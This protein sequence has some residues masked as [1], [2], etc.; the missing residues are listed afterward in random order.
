MGAWVIEFLPTFY[1]F[2]DSP[3]NYLRSY[4]LQWGR[5]DTLSKLQSRLSSPVGGVDYR[6]IT[7]L[8]SG[9]PPIPSGTKPYFTADI[10]LQLVSI[11]T[12]DWP[13]SSKRANFVLDGPFVVDRL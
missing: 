10:P 3:A 13:Y 5:A 9:L 1:A 7:L 6:E 2:Y 8:E 12:T 11:I 4:R